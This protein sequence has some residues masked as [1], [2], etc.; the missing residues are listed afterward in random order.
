M[1]TAAPEAKAVYRDRLQQHRKGERLIQGVGYGGGKGCAIGCTLESYDHEKFARVG[2][3]PVWLAYLI[4]HI[5]EG[6]PKGEAEQFADDAITALAALPAGLDL[7]PIQHRLTVKRMD[8]LLAGLEGNPAEECRKALLMVR[9][10]ALDGGKDE[11][12]RIAAESEARRVVESAKSA[13]WHAESVESAESARSV[14]CAA[15]SAVC[16]AADSARST[17]R[18]A[19]YSAAESAARNAARSTANN[20]A[21]SAAWNAARSAAYRSEAAALLAELRGESL[22]AQYTS[23]PKA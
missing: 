21:R 16:G 3:G 20:A 22:H 2:L 5:F 23:G 19:V 12:A 17:A 1:L 15:E 7:D 8:R 10:W 11:R 14:M 4:D 9:D 6:L 13:T 18:S